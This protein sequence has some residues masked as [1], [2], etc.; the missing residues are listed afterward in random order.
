MTSPVSVY[1]F[2]RRGDGEADSVRPIVIAMVIVALVLTATA[3]VRVTNQHEVLRLGYQLSKRSDEVRR[4]RE[5]KRQLELERA[6]LSA[7]DRIRKLATRLGMTQ[8]APDR[9]RV[10][11]PRHEV[12]TR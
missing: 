2:F 9:I 5:L 6:T 8:V 10:I 3:V 4:L 11:R 7:P 12:A 1:R